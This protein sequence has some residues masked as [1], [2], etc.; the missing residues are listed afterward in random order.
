MVKQGTATHVIHYLPF[1]NQ[2]HFCSLYATVL[3]DLTET[4]SRWLCWTF[5][6]ESRRGPRQPHMVSKSI[7]TMPTIGCTIMPPKKCRQAK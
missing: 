1:N 5:V 2:Y 7:T 3:H 6:I 4:A